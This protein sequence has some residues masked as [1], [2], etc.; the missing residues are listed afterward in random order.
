MKLLNIL[1]NNYSSIKPG[2]KKDLLEH[3][4]T[5][6]KMNSEGTGGSGE[7]AVK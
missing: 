2:G 7:I 5:Q 6:I 1:Y 3:F 4:K